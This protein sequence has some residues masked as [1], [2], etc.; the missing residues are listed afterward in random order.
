LRSSSSNKIG[1]GKIAARLQSLVTL[2]GDDTELH[3]NEIVVGVCEECRS[4]VSPGPL[5]R[6][7]GWR[8]ELRD[9]VAGGTLRRIVEGRQILLHRAI[10]PRQIAI[11]SPVLPCDRALLVGV[12]RDQTGI[13]G[14][15]FTTNKTGGNARLDNPLE[16]AAKNIPLAETLVAGARK[17]R[18]IRD[19]VLNT[20]FAEPTPIPRLRGS[21]LQAE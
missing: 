14:K 21:I 13:D 9:N 6:G 16:H 17:C 19:S 18:M 7:I 12:G 1:S 15:A 10:G 4:L 11:P 3:I 20:E 5:R 2:T 8:D